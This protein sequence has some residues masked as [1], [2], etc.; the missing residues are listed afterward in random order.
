MVDLE[1]VR[2]HFAVDENVHAEDLKA[3]LDHVM[4]WKTRV[5]VVLEHRQGAEN[6]FDDDIV[7]VRPKLRDIVALVGENAVQRRDFPLRADFIVR[8]VHSTVLV[9]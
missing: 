4:R 3:R 1:D 5:V 8:R 2:L 6:R 7:N 9:N